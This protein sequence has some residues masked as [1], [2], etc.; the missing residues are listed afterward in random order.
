MV[1][2]MKP[3]GELQNQYMD[4]YDEWIHSGEE[5][6]PWVIERDPADF[7]GMLQFLEDTERAL[8]LPEGWV[9]S[10]TYWLVTDDSRAVVGAVNI[11]HRLNEALLNRGG[12]IGYGIRPS[13]RQKGY[14][15][16]LLKQ[17]LQK[18]KDMGL[19]KA[20][21]VCDAVNI[22]SERTIRRNG[23]V[24]DSAYTEDSGNVIKRFW[25]EI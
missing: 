18:M 24:E 16:E 10:T 13:E 1:T 7:R 8:N 9:P 12:H 23:G 14:A 22:A 17:S 15:A 19:D 5:M 2:L 21:V 3:C 6:V 4:F 25:I 20:L 11:R